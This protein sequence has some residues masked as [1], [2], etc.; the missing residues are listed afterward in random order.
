ML[1]ALK[2]NPNLIAEIL[3]FENNTQSLAQALEVKGYTEDA[4]EL[5][6]LNPKKFLWS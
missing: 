5:M 6:L 4:V 1:L 2:V 3:H